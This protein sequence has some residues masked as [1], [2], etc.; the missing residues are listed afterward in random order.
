MRTHKEID[1]STGC[2][3]GTV[4]LIRLL[5]TPLYYNEM[6]RQ[7][8]P[9]AF[10]LRLTGKNHDQKETFV[11]LIRRDKFDDDE[12]FLSALEVGYVIWDKKPWETN[13]YYGYG[14]FVC[15]EALAVNDMI[16]IWPLLQS[17]EYHVGMFYAKSD[18][19]YYSGP[20][21]KDNPDILEM[22]SDL[23]DLISDTV[24]TTSEKK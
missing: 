21:P 9:D 14:T 13:R 22:L 19:E 10:D 15:Q 24:V 3:D 18:D 7:V 11:S 20:L 1:T 17:K 12:S 6:T 23:A 5:C 2:V 4:S 8:N 16:E